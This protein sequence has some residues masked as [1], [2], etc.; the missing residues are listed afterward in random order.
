MDCHCSQAQ[1]GLCVQLENAIMTME[2][3]RSRH[4]QTHAEYSLLLLMETRPASTHA[5]QRIR[6]VVPYHILPVVLL[7]RSLEFGATND[8]LFALSAIL[9]FRIAFKL[10]FFPEMRGTKSE[11]QLLKVNVIFVKTPSNSIFSRQLK[12]C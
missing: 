12:R 9:L 8:F 11:T 3:K 5:E 2:V 4:L 6:W 7:L 10:V 1:G